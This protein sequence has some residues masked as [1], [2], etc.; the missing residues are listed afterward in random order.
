M[1][2]ERR[3]SLTGAAALLVALPLV[4]S[5]QTAPTEPTVFFACYGSLTGVV[6]RIKEPGLPTNCLHRT[7]VQFS[8]TSGDG[9]AALTDHGALQGLGDDDHPQYLLVDGSRALTASLSAGGNKL[10]GL[11]AAEVDGDAVRYEQAVKSG[12]GAGGDLLG[13]TYP[14]PTVAKLQGTGLS[15]T[16][17]TDKQVLTY[18]AANSRWAPAA[19]AAASGGTV[20]GYPG[21]FVNPTDGQAF[22]GGTGETATGGG[23]ELLDNNRATLMSSY[24]SF[25]SV[26]GR[27]N[28]WRVRYDTP[29]VMGARVYV[30][31]VR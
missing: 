31:C 29:G 8:W 7:H 24:P 27:P 1:T 3:F 28:G 4:A 17:P 10:T 30:I 12:D 15:S 14:N 21:V 25:S 13:S 5:A 9:G 26:T 6:Y 18:D 2:R 22:C 20:T 16:A 23:V 11:A 19:P